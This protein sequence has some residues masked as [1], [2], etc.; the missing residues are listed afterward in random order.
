MYSKIIGATAVIALFSRP[1]LSQNPLNLPVLDVSSL[2][3]YP[4]KNVLDNKLNGVLQC[5]FS[6]RDAD[7]SCIRIFGN[8]FEELHL[9][10]CLD[11]IEAFSEVNER[12]IEIASTE[13]HNIF[14][15]LHICMH[16]SGKEGGC[17]DCGT[18]DQTIDA[19]TNVVDSSL[20]DYFDYEY[21]STNDQVELQVD[22]FPSY[23][24]RSSDIPEHDIL[25]DVEYHLL[26]FRDYVVRRELDQRNFFPTLYA[27]LEKY[28]SAGYRGSKYV[29]VEFQQCMV[30]ASRRYGDLYEELIPG[31]RKLLEVYQTEVV[32]GDNS[33]TTMV[34]LVYNQFFNSK[35]EQFDRVVKEL[36]NAANAPNFQGFTERL[37][38]STSS[39]K[40][41]ADGVNVEV[42]ASDGE[43]NSSPATIVNVMLVATLI[44]IQYIVF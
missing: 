19:V 27:L 8:D 35:F 13:F 18:F 9:S 29:G 5:M 14:N 25:E 32:T 28:D 39:F 12:Y 23:R 3:D 44:V 40:S 26:Y 17:T 20:K 43:G 22:I 31:I 33:Y 15:S 1:T 16:V 41:F 11:P 2:K 30:S 10:E 21:N 37:E 36:L 42:A 38:G 24:R 7:E 34:G 4:C 6:P